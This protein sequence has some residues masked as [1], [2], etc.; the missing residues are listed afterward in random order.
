MLLL[1]AATTL[2]AQTIL[3]GDMNNDNEVTIADVTLLIDLML[4]GE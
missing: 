1:L 3:K 4:K 2:S